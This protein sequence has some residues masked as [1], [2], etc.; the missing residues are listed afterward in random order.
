MTLLPD[1]SI[2]TVEMHTGGEPVRIVVGGW[3]EVPGT[4]ILDKR[5]AGTTACMACYL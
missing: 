4:T 5:R 3:P 2:D 1:Q